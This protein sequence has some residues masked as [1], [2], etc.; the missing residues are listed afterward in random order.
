MATA[1]SD[2]YESGSSRETSPKRSL[3]ISKSLKGLFKTSNG[4]NAANT[5]V[6]NDVPLLSTKEK[7]DGLKSMASSKE[8]ELLSCRGGATKGQ[9]ISPPK[10]SGITGLGK[11]SMPSRRHGGLDTYGSQ[12]SII[13]DEERTSAG[14]GKEGSSYVPLSTSPIDRDS[15]V[16]NQCLS[17]NSQLENDGR[18]D[19]ELSKNPKETE[20][21]VRRSRSIQ[22]HRNNSFA[23]R[24]RAASNPAQR[25]SNAQ[26]ENRERANTASID[27]LLSHENESRCVIKTE[28]FAVYEDGHHIHNLRVVPLVNDIDHLLAKHKTSFSLSGFFKP[29]RSSVDE[30]ENLGTALSLLPENRQN[31]HKR[32]SQII[33]EE[34]P[35]DNEAADENSSGSE[36][37]DVDS[38]EESNSDLG[39]GSETQTS[40]GVSKQSSVPKM[41]NKDSVI[42]TA[43]LKLIN[44]LSEKIEH[45]FSPTVEVC[46]TS[47]STITKKQHFCEKYGNSIG[48][49][50][51]GAYGV[52]KLCY[53]PATS[54][55]LVTKA[56]TYLQDGKFF[57][58]VK[59]LKA[60]PDESTE[61]FN[62]R[63]TSEFVIG[64]SLSGGNKSK[65][66]QSRGHPN[67]LN[68]FDLMQ[69]S[70]AFYEVMEFCPSGDLY[71]LMTRTSKS[72]NY[73]H[74]LEA[75]CFM[76]QLLNAV[77][78]M[79][80]HGVAH[81][82]LKPENLLFLPTG[83]LKVC[84]FGTS[85][86]FQTAWEKKVHFQTGAAGSEP[87]V[88]PEEFIPKNQYDP[89]LVDCWSCGIIYCVMILG[90]YLWKSAIKGKDA[91]YDAF[92][93]DMEKHEEYYVF[94]EM[95]HVSSEIN[96]CRR[97]ALY[98]IFQVEPTRRISV[99]KLLNS[100]WMKKTKCCIEY[101][102]KKT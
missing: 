12:E 70:T 47:D 93:E 72:G 79:H 23:F 63:L 24:P 69:T 25:S 59:E 37:T 55:E 42:G 1:D 40:N 48:V 84:D 62:T 31:F 16:R 80:Q 13:S 14:S 22:S 74:P 64:L 15:M 82:D 90:H 100:A 67:I 6:T 76:K 95:R 87:Y 50:G 27:I 88:A 34:D 78:Y 19:V 83:V 73:L 99:D 49:L 53:K 10:H 9:N 57:Y 77:K 81:C 85:S 18:I 58:A 94:E 21:S 68:V 96:R 60:R 44:Q 30:N 11:L 46:S 32:L 51:Q 66:P 4:A 101:D 56:K 38:S 5:Q 86:V 33:D 54:T 97:A 28:R 2:I 71:S 7:H 65:P 26:R 35:R 52:V 20:A 43:E 36:S 98:H 75:D 17:Y 45:G 3:S 102:R 61:K 41:V 89:R 29:N 91:V 8:K 39:S 92:L